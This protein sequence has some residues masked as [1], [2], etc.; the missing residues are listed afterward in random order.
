[1]VLDSSP[2]LQHAGYLFLRL[3]LLLDLL[4]SFI[5]HGPESKLC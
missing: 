3:G 1:M 2:A 4:D 5:V